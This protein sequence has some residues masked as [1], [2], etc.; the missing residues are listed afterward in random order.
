MMPT[1]EEGQQPRPGRLTG[2]PAR[3]EGED[4]DEEHQFEAR[5][6]EPGAEGEVARQGRIQRHS[7]ENA[8]CRREPVFIV[9]ALA[10]PAD[11]RLVS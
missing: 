2:E 5:Y 6:D 8:E 7:D 1:S 3:I 4:R 10:W 9:A 11:H